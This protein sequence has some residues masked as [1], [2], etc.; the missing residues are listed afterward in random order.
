[1]ENKSFLETPIPSEKYPIRVKLITLL[2]DNTPDY[3]LHRHEHVEFLYVISGE[4]TV[5]HS[6]ERVRAK[7]DDF[8]IVNFN[9]IHATEM[10]EDCRM[11][12]VQI[13]PV[14]FSSVSF[15]SPSFK[16]H[17][18]KD[19]NISKYMLRIFDEHN[20]KKLGYD[21]EIM[22]L[23]YSLMSYLVRNYIERRDEPHRADKR[24]HKISEIISYVSLHYAEHITTA[25]LAEHFFLSEYY[26]CRFFKESTGL[27]LTDY[28]NKYR[29]ATAASLLKSTDLSVTEIALRVGFADSNYFTKI[30]KKHKGKS[31]REFKKT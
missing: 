3:P 2:T 26:F 23:C 1:M 30:F 14:F 13:S 24:A 4:C 29:V 11:V 20:S 12:C 25:Q 9:E 22:G 5:I 21:M 31:P 28:I 19:A 7:R 27:T 17:I 18:E 10:S 16:S 6:G 15:E 8:V